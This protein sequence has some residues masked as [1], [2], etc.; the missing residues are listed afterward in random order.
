[1]GSTGATALFHAAYLFIGILMMLYFRNQSSEELA[2]SNLLKTKNAELT[3]NEDLLKTKNADQAV[4]LRE[5][6]GAKSK[7]NKAMERLRQAEGAK[8]KAHK[9]TIKDQWRSTY[10]DKTTAMLPKYFPSYDDS[11]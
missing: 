9:A 4:L 7:A 6:E 3:T 10:P 11:S 2:K 1:M 8:S 5:A